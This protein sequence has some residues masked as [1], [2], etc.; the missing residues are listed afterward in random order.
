MEIDAAID[1]LNK[2]KKLS[3][4]LGIADCNIIGLDNESFTVCVVFGENTHI[5]EHKTVLGF[6]HRQ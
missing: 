6:N 4:K 3:S 1:K 2:F 5:E